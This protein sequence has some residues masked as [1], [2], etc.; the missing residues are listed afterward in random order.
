MRCDHGATVQGLTERLPFASSVNESA[1]TL[2]LSVRQPGVGGG[3]Y[4]EPTINGN[5]IF[6]IAPELPRIRMKSSKIL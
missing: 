4:L 2:R 3:V 6:L 1:E 5:D